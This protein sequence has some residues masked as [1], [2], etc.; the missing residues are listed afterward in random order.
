MP[1]PRK[2][3]EEARLRGDLIE[4]HTPLPS[5]GADGL[6]PCPC[7]GGPAFPSP[8]QL[9]GHILATRDYHDALKPWAAS[10]LHAR[11]PSDHRLEDIHHHLSEY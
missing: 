9:A 11:F 7:C 6:W 5:V 3:A 8:Q 10:M 4:P 2:Q 1:S